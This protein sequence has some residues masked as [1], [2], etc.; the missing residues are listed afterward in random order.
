MTNTEGP[1]QPSPSERPW[2][3]GPVT[4]AE[5]TAGLVWPMLLRT[6][7]IAIQ[8]PR[9]LIGV[10]TMLVLWGIGSL[11]DGIL[12]I[13]GGS[14]I[15]SPL[16]WRI[17][18]GWM[19]A[20]ELFISLRFADSMDALQ[21]ALLDYPALLLVERPFTTALLALILAPLLAIGFGAIARSAAVDLA[22]GMNMGVRESIGFALR[23]W[24]SLAGAVLIPLALVA[25]GV[26]FLKI[27]GWLLLGLPGLNIIGAL[28]YGIFILVGL[29]LFV[30]FVGCI[31]GHAMLAPAVVVESTDS[32]DAIQRIY[33]YLLGR[34]GRSLLYLSIVALQMLIAFGIIVAA[35][36][37]STALTADLAG[38]FL[39]PDRA[40]ALFE[41]ARSDTAAAKII[42]F[43]HLMVAL[44]LSGLLISWHA[45]AGTLV[46]LLLRRACDEQDVREVWMP[47][48][49]P[50]TRA[51]EP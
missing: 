37:A 48:L 29:A 46:Y 19:D 38:S 17:R 45:T 49:V 16:I 22:V 34:P 24:R 42:A 4:L 7:V 2:R 14:P 13:G 23:R 44:A 8:P 27:A 15:A 6:A 18:D 41:P 3:G 51:G 40:A 43:W 28:F 5:L 32:V 25:A 10:L 50:G 35:V 30:L 36:N 26:V 11:F 31:I 47:G 1:S 20:A 33:A 21:G 39:P 12:S 9:I